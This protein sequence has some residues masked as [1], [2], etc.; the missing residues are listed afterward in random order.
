MKLLQNQ[1]NLCFYREDQQ[2]AE[3]SY[4]SSHFTS[5]GRSGSESES[6][7]LLHPTGV[8]PPHL[9]AANVSYPAAFSGKL[10]LPKNQN[11][12][13][14]DPAGGHIGNAGR[15][16]LLQSSLIL[17]DGTEMGWLP[18]EHLPRTLS[19]GLQSTVIESRGGSKRA[20][21]SPPSKIDIIF[22][23]YLTDIENATMGE[24]TSPRVAPGGATKP[25]GGL[26]RTPAH[27]LSQLGQK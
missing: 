15:D 17:P 2:D 1:V 22:N 16:D 14:P 18:A 9:A 11:L 10:S 3:H 26:Q 8:V 24:F 25:G 21:P 20:K 5:E 12:G 27:D 6:S 23:N 4:F 13:K 7:T 19:P